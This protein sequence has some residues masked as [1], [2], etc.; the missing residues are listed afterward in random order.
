MVSEEELLQE[1][2]A[3]RYEDIIQ[4]LPGR[5]LPKRYRIDQLLSTNPYTAI[6]RTFNEQKETVV[7]LRVFR[8][9]IKNEEDYQYRRFK[10]EV[11]KLSG[12]NHINIAK[13]LDN[14]LLEEGLPYIVLENIEGPT[15]SEVLVHQNRLESVQAGLVFSQIA[16]GVQYAHDQGVL[17]ETLKPSRILITETEDGDAVVKINGF[18]LLSCYNKL[19]MSMKT[20]KTKAEFIG[21][22]AYMSPEQ[23]YE[24]TP[25]DGR[26]DIYSIGCMMYEALSGQ[27]PFLANTDEATMR[28]HLETEP[29][30]IPVLRKDL[31]EFP[32]RLLAIVDK[33]MVKDPTRR[34]QFVKDLQSDIE[35]DIDP[36]E[37]EKRVV[38]PEA[39][40]K[41]EHLVKENKESPVRF[42][43]TIVAACIGLFGVVF[44]GYYLYNVT[45]QIADN[46]IWQSKLDAGNKAFAEGK[47][48]EAIETLKAAITEAEKF[49]APDL[50]MAKT[51]NDNGYVNIVCGRYTDALTDL[52]KALQI[53]SR[54]KT[55]DDDVE[56]RTNQLLS[57]AELAAG[58]AGEAEAHANAAVQIAERM[59]GEHTERLYR[60]YNQLFRIML[61]KNDLVQAKVAIDKMKTAFSHTN[62]MLP[63][64]IISGEKQAEAQVAQAEGKLDVAEKGYQDVLGSRQEKI[65][66]GSLPAIE[67]YVLLGKLYF[68]QGKND[69]S[70]KILTTAMENKQKVLGEKSPAVAEQCFLIAL[71]YDKAKNVSMAEKYYRQSL[72]MAEKDFGKGEMETLPY[73]VSL[74]K[75]LREHKQVSAAQVYETEALEIQHPE[76]VPQFLKEKKKKK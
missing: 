4:S 1:P 69:K 60:A 48:E 44:G 34:Y 70:I 62:V 57:E 37:R 43:L 27:V 73:V 11:K 30:P 76:R 17:H 18:G 16:R 19:G 21:S 8:I 13:I 23:C 24:G 68:Q 39:I 22:A 6:Y 59:T 64:E 26:S 12:L 3:N 42:I 51:L 61:A 45:S 14:G 32:K 49:P 40:Q 41:A 2:V 5:I 28:M 7:N 38:I 55:K 31:T 46:G 29:T 52:R 66:P 67:T 9:L 15:L 25:V 10:Q 47:T 36:E 33:C 58:K 35:R 71:V 56:S 74:A 63:M 54:A 75:F 65:G 72:E 53:E 20:P 50:R